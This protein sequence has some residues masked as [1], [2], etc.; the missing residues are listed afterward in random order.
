MTSYAT[1]GGVVDRFIEDY[2]IDPEDV[3]GVDLGT[4]IRLH[5]YRRV[6]GLDYILSS[7]STTHHVANLI[8]EDVPIEVTYVSSPSKEEAA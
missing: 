3:I 1:L 2:K 4:T 5:I 6:D 8:R 7:W